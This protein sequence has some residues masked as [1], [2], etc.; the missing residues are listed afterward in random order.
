MI[1]ELF[2]LSLKYIYVFVQHK[3]YCTYIFIK[4]NYKHTIPQVLFNT[5]Q[6]KTLILIINYKN[7]SYILFHI[8]DLSGI[9]K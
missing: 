6:L 9:K 8:F 5:N 2:N 3:L 4:I 1:N 7:M